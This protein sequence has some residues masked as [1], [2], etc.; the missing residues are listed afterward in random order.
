MA[1]KSIYFQEYCEYFGEVN[2][3]NMPRSYNGC[4]RRILGYCEEKP[5]LNSIPWL[6]NTMGFTSGLGAKVSSRYY[7][8]LTFLGY[9]FTIPFLMLVQI[10]Y[11]H[12]V[13]DLNHFIYMPSR[14][15]S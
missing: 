8:S 9:L 7:A 15:V 5:E 12:F 6:I 4:V 14:S 10:V 1:C 13:D 11:K 2:V 3:S